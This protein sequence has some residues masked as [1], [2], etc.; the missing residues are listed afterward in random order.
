MD[1]ALARA[2]AWLR[3]ADGLLITAGA[4]MG[5]DSGLPD[6]RGPGGFWA[7]YPA[8]GRAGIR[9]EAIANPDA[10]RRDPRQAWGFYGHRLALYRA[11]QPHAGFAMLREIAATMAN[12]A[13]VFTSN[14]DGQ[15]QKA[16]FAAERICEIH[17][18]IHHLQC[19]DGCSERIWRADDFQPVIDDENCHLLNEL[20]HCPA[21]GALAR[22]NILMFDDWGWVDRRSALQEDHLAQWLAKVRNL[23]VIEIGAGTAIPS[24]RDFSEN[25]GG[26]LVR[27]NPDEAEVPG[28]GRAIPLPLAGL[29]GI[30]LLHQSLAKE[31]STRSLGKA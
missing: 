26:Q 25:C 21:C 11:T 24:V 1:A 18:S 4:G 30:T 19:A 16:G 23:L 22:P 13:F 8:L 28:N 14:V 9:F 27:I 5:I 15:F 3:T 20:P 12:G 2:A 10:F 31:A 17:G 29:A 6:F 7:A